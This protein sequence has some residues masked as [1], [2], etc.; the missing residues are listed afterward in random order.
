MTHRANFQTRSAQ[1]STDFGLE[2]ATKWF[3]QEVVDSL[4]KYVR[5]K[6]K[7]KPK[8]F[9]E[10]TKVTRGGWVPDRYSPDGGYV[11]NRSGAIIRRDL[12]HLES[13]RYGA[14]VGDHVVYEH[15]DHKYP[16]RLGLGETLQELVQDHRRNMRVSYANSALIAL[17][18]FRECMRTIRQLRGVGTHNPKTGEKYTED[19]LEAVAALIEDKREDARINLGGWYEAMAMYGSWL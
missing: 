3:G 1:L 19:Q 17:E 4:P 5:G 15:D 9:Y 6:N 8:G 18:E 10:W 16:C 7:G 2:M 11:E 14:C 12:M 13:G